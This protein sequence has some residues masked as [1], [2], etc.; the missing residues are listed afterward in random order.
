MSAAVKKI[1]SILTSIYSTANY[2]ELMQEIFDTMNLVAPNNFRREY[3]NFSN[4]I[5]GSI[6]IGNYVDPEKKKIAIFAV[7]L[8]KEE[9]VENSRSA[10]RNYAKKLIEGGSC[11]A[12]IIAFYTE[13]ES[14]WRLSFVRLEYEISV[15]EGAL[16]TKEK[17][18]PA[19]RYSFLVGKNEPSHTAID[20]FHRFIIDNNY[21][22]TLD[23]VE[24]AFS[25]EKVT[26]EFFESYCEKF[27]QLHET[28]EKIEDF[29]IESSRHNF[30]AAQFAKKL[31][32]QIV[33]LYFLQKKG[34]LG[35][36][37]F[38]DV[39]SKQEYDVACFSCGAKSRELIPKVF[40]YVDG[41]QYKLSV[42][43]LNA[44]GSD[45]KAIIAQSVKGKPWGSG[46]HDFMRRLFNAS[47]Q[48]GKNFYNDVLEPLF[49]DTLNRNRGAQGYCVS[50]ECRIPFLSGGLFE[51]LEG[52]DWQHNCFDIPN[53][54]FSNVF[55]KGRNADGI[56]DVFERYNFTMSEDE[57]M[58]REVAID[59][60]M[61][62]KV[63][64][65][66]LEVKD[67]KTR[68]AFYTPREIVYYICRESL[69]SYLVRTTSLSED[70]IRAFVI[71]GDA[72]VADD[73]HQQKRKQDGKHWIP[74]E[75]FTISSN[76]VANTTN[77]A[78]I[79]DALSKVKIADPA[80]G[81][82]AFPLCMVNE[83]VRIRQ[84][85]TE[86]LTSGMSEAEKKIAC[87]N[88]RSAYW[89]KYNTIQNSIFA[90]DIDPSAVD[91]A[92]LRLW[93]SLVIEIEANSDT[94][95]L[96]EGFSSQ[97]T[98]PDLDEH[99]ICGDSLL[100]TPEYIGELCNLDIQSEKYSRILS[101]MIGDQRLLFS[102]DDPNKKSQLCAM[103]RSEK[104]NIVELV[105]GQ[106]SLALYRAMKDAS[107]FAFWRLDFAEVFSEKGG[108]DIVVGNPP[109]VQL[110]SS[111]DAN[112]EEKVGDKYASL[113]YT[114]FSKTG[115]MYCLFYELGMSLLCK[116]GCLSYITSNKW[117]RTKY[118]KP[119]RKLFSENNN[120]KIIIDFSGTRV[121]KTAQVDVSI[122]LIEK[123][124]NQSS[125]LACTIDQLCDCSFE[126]Y[127][128]KN[129]VQVP[130][131][132]DEIW[133][134]ASGAD[135][136]IKNKICSIGKPISEWGLLIKYGI[137]TGLNDAFVVDDYTKQQLCE[138]DPASIEL[139]RPVLKGRDI[140]KWGFDYRGL[141]I[142][143]VHNGVDRRIPRVNID[144]YSA[145][146]NHL[147]LYY[148]K[149]CKRADKGAT[150]YHLR[151][152]A[153]LE[154]FDE[155]KIIFQE[156]VQSPSFA[157]DANG[158][159]MCLDTAR[160]ITGEHLEYLTGL[161]N[162]N[163]FFFAVKHF[164][165]G[166]KLGGNGIRMKH[167]FFKDFSAY[168]PSRDEEEYIKGLV[169]SDGVDKDRLIN[170]FFYS[171]YLLSPE[172]IS[173]IEKDI[174]VNT[175]N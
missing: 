62:G 57:P 77:L 102:T 73:I 109:Y 172:E 7:Q 97:I 28:L 88:E 169:L 118:G 146:K 24:D 112:G 104:E 125:T 141:W 20:R 168:V 19:K 140:N 103:I 63:F 39:I 114:V 150:P 123:M 110:Q 155:P 59:P 44:M 82:G 66:L 52:Y 128:H 100:N 46:P 79:D 80:V 58:E 126:Q 95:S 61:L 60:E 67:R 171:K 94:T 174:S 64:E 68:G 159:Y 48:Q 12:A 101:R 38:P 33:F 4:H 56:L 37:A 13:G 175:E 166:G 164:F 127:V 170:E 154:S 47:V 113:N 76:G 70:S 152:C 81:S 34:W 2:V 43:V 111:I 84:N 145:V 137:K 132:T 116:G 115:D 89:L 3:S 135:E 35:V 75:L 15:E 85:I 22:P 74:Q 143:V 69:I 160:I 122:L 21:N 144:K 8:K 45:D 165:S 49:Y 157:F 71:Y 131:V 41:K 51:P 98:L 133:N 6:H 93:L 106:G 86:Y 120:P 29:Q 96:V 40:E 108:F 162:S 142:I 158:Q 90:V 18:T 119:L 14:K 31:M 117:L 153:Y 83:I 173:Y 124:S 121:F 129:F 167:T 134:I 161:F 107:P 163:L 27:H 1:E 151:D 139:L 36:D 54:I 65:N 55:D 99:I 10:Q 17:L 11:D 16:K 9:Y 30:T 92:K 149:L 78:K 105:G 26:D 91:V 53:E 138:E 5:E 42:S 32:G 156:M 130:F 136:S 87:V 72:M 148:E 147:N 23:E 50:L 25:V